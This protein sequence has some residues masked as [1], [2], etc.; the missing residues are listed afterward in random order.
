VTLSPYLWLYSPC[1]PWSLFQFLNLFTVGRIP[2]TGIST[3][4]SMPRVGFEG[5]KIVDVLDRAAT[6]IGRYVTLASVVLSDL[7]GKISLEKLMWSLNYS[8]SSVPLMDH[9][10]RHRPYSFVKN[11]TN[12]L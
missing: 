3:Q 2:R 7:T 8:G 9:E 5:F 11:S 1:G 10:T 4:T 6:V 12:R